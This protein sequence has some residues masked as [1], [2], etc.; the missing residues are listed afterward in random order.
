MFASQF[1]KLCTYV[2]SI[3]AP[4]NAIVGTAFKITA[5][6]IRSSAEPRIYR[7]T[8]RGD[9][10]DYEIDIDVS[11][12][13]RDAKLFSEGL[14][15][16][17]TQEWLNDRVNAAVLGYV[18]DVAVNFAPG[19]WT[20]DVRLVG[21]EGFKFD[22]VPERALYSFASPVLRQLEAKIPPCEYGE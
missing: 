16:K 15:S 4:P 2:T 20:A 6:S 5:R 1:R 12:L 9:I 3:E 7:Q 14:Q 21:T 17:Q 18:K 19:K 8:Q 22:I 11:S 10:Y 13:L